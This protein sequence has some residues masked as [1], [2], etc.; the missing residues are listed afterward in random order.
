MIKTSTESI[1]PEVPNTPSQKSD[2]VSSLKD[3][4]PENIRENIYDLVPEESEKPT[5]FFRSSPTIE[6]GYDII[7]LGCNHQISCLELQD[8]LHQEST[9]CPCCEKP[10]ISSLESPQGKILL[11][12][13]GNVLPRLLKQAQSNGAAI[14]C[15]KITSSFHALAKRRIQEEILNLEKKIFCKYPFQGVSGL[16]KLQELWMATA[17]EY[18]FSFPGEKSREIFENFLEENGLSKETATFIDYG[19]GPGVWSFFLHENGFQVKAVESEDTK[20]LYF[21][22]HT[23]S[24]LTELPISIEAVRRQSLALPED[25][26]NHILFLS[27]PENTRIPGQRPY[28]HK[29]LEEFAKKGGTLAIYIGTPPGG[30]CETAGPRFFKEIDEKWDSKI[31]EKEEDTFR[32]YTLNGTS[33]KDYLYL[34]TKRSIH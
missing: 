29:V 21:E 30:S 26:H 25:C 7:T 31:L 4:I 20:P 16:E 33:E 5:I 19:A 24:F 17:S 23:K 6:K 1:T 8:V 28:A 14:S 12:V 3:P 2:S 10:F 32:S 18:G 11:D 9:C 15:N 13:F 34:L 27:Y 22:K